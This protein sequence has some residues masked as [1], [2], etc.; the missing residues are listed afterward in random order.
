MDVF[1]GK[2]HEGSS[3]TELEAFR[4]ELLEFINI[5]STESLESV[6]RF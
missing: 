6:N 5:W 2:D 1:Q 4:G 3:R